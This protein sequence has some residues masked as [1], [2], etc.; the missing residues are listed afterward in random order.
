MHEILVASGQINQSESVLHMAFQ[1]TSNCHIYRPRK[2]P[3]DHWV[4]LHTL[5]IFIFSEAPSLQQILIFRSPIIQRIQIGH[6][7]TIHCIFI[8]LLVGRP[9]LPP[10]F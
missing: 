3:A 6:R 7:S 2:S 9:P 4:T 8:K 10:Y 5:F 1:G